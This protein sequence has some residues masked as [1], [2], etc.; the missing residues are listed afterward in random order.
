MNRQLYL[1]LLSLTSFYSGAQN[2]KIDKIT[3][4]DF[5]EQFYELDPTASAVVEHNLGK[6][7]FIVVGNHFQLVT[8]TKTRIKIFK[9]D[10]Y[11]YATISIPLYRDRSTRELLSVSNAYTYNLV[12]GKVE[13]TRLD[14][15]AEFVEKVQGNYYLASFTM[16]N[17]KEGS[18]IEYT[19]KV[20]SPY[21]T[22]IPEWYFQL[23]IPVK[24]S[25]FELK[26]P[27]KYRFYK[28][29]KGTEKVN[30]RILG[31][32][33][34][35]TAKNIPALKEESYVNNIDN[36]RTSIIHTFSAY[37]EENGNFKTF[38]GTWTE[39][40]SA[41]N[42][43][44]GFGGRLKKTDFVKLEA[45]KIVANLNSDVDKAN[46]IVRFLQNEFTWNQALGIEASKDLKDVMQSKSGSS[47]EINLLGIS[48]MRSVGLNAHPILLA[49]RNKGIAYMPSVSAFNNVIIG[50]E[51]N[52]GNVVLFDASDKFSKN[53][54]LP[55]H[56][57]NW[58]G[59][60]VR[61]DG[62][63][64]DVLLEPK[65]KSRRSINAV[66]SLNP[67]TGSIQGKLYVSR[68]NYEAYLYRNFNKQLS[69]EK[70]ADAYEERYGVEIDSFHLS[71]FD[72]LEENVIENMTIKRPHSF[73][74]IGDKIY[75]TPA[76]IFKR[77]ENPF[78]LD[79]RMY[80]LDFIYPSEEAYTL[81]YNIPVGY[82]VENV[83][84]RK[85]ISTGTNSVSAQWIISHDE[86]QIRVRWSLSQNNAIV[87]AGEYSDVKTVYEELVKFMDQKI[88]LKRK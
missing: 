17:V 44:D 60:L 79:Q 38:G 86:Q 18:I 23:D 77:N 58:I 41:I 56:N 69:S 57:L 78:K 52:T 20:T 46:A 13:R 61:P 53:D 40:V 11:D 50:L 43:Y 81:V 45:L 15:S 75:L 26:I 8:E 6:T 59:R 34:V 63:S 62:T 31:D 29:I 74:I 72:D 12:D 9:K 2:F 51:S 54:I 19:T 80:P 35:Y 84:D 30:Q 7:Y 87:D 5:E 85:K 47:P 10:A 68:N 25:E 36:Y 24:I 70:I 1:F 39:V 88:V 65:V 55:I 67:A 33:Y 14:S 37:R 73:D 71:N 66:L 42:N 49:T 82:E 3:K 76:F 28:Y 22:D 16:P 48:M 64:K 83:P 21:I 27:E 32:K 4:K